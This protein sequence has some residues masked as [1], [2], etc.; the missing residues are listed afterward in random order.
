MVLV[1]VAVCILEIH[2]PE[3]ASLKKKRQVLQSLIKRLRNRFNISIAE[4][5]CNDLWQRSELGV[6]AICRN[7]GSAHR[8]MEQVNSFIEQESNIDIISSKVEIY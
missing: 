1:R 4:V 5:G 3:A 6:A 2:I 7:S 8:V